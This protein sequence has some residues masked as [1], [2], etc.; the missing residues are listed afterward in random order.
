MKVLC[1]DHV[2]VAVRN[3]P[4]SVRWYQEVLGLER[5]F[6][7]EWGDNPAYLVVAGSTGIALF[8]ASSPEINGTAPSIRIL[9]LAF[10]VNLKNFKRAQAELDALGI[11]YRF[12]NH[13]GV[14][15]SI[16]FQD[17]D[18]HQIELTAYQ[19]MMHVPMSED[20]E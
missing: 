4:R 14:S 6:E 9:H 10:R 7:Q 16:Y 19:G 13:H 12:E 5:R 18:G 3:L 15:D 11:A 17:P 20:E 8:Q 1:L 2:A